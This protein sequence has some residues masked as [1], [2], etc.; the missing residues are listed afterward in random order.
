MTIMLIGNKSDLEQ[1]R[2][3]SLDEGEKFA[4]MNG[5]MFMETSALN[6]N[7]VDEAFTQMTRNIYTQIQENK[8][9]LSNDSNGI[10]VGHQNTQTR[11]PQAKKSSC[12]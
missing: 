12:C 1:D 9:D 8:F 7:N 10:K 11:Q 2:V 6:G 4:R 5:L 3:V